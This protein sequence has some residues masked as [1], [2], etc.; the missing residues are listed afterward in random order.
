MNYFLQFFFLGIQR[1]EEQMDQLIKEMGNMRIQ[2]QDIKKEME[3]VKGQLKDTKTELNETKIQLEESKI[4]REETK[5]QLEN[6]KTELNETK[7]QLEESKIQIEETKIQ[8]QNTKTELLN[9]TKN[10]LKESKIQLDESKIQLDKSKIQLDESKIQL[11]ESKIQLDESKTKISDLGE[12]LKNIEELGKT[13]TKDILA[14]SEMMKPL[15]ERFEYAK[16]PCRNCYGPVYCLDGKVVG[17]RPRDGTRIK[18]GGFDK[19]WGKDKNGEA[20]A[21]RYATGFVYENRIDWD[22]VM[23]KPA[24]SKGST[25]DDIY[26]NKFVYRCFK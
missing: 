4:Q 16:N 11:D 7:I 15:L 5:I 18:T 19:Y 17:T 25:Y 6:T 1:T 8:L 12:T 14:N 26:F 9:E 22:D 21:V 10:Q 3:Y 13:N 24:G 23:Y 20:V 2:F